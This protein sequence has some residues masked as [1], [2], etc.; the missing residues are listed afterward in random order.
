MFV[1]GHGQKSE[2]KHRT[3]N[4]AK[5][6]NHLPLLTMFE[7]MR[8]NC[9]FCVGRVVGIREKL[10]IQQNYFICRK[11]SNSSTYTL[12]NFCFIIQGEAKSQLIMFQGCVF[13]LRF[14]FSM[15]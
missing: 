3:K 10:K 15:K 4:L 1:Q 6:P 12:N 14:S 8:S 7:L 5:L 11:T 2:Q 13:L 9:Q